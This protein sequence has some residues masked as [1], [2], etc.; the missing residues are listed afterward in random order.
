MKRNLFILICIIILIIT[1]FVAYK[2]YESNSIYH[3]S[4]FDKKYF[5]DMGFV[6]KS[7]N[8]KPKVDKNEILR[9][10]KAMQQQ[11]SSHP[12][13]IYMQYGLISTNTFTINAIS[14]DAINADP[15]LKEKDSISDIPVWIITFSGL[16][17]DNYKP[18][19]NVIGKQPLDTTNTII[20]AI[21]GKILLEFGSG[22]RP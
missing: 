15:I 19:K 18:D 11:S 9:I 5:S 21:S 22:K 16:L 13:G 8:I 6:I 12:K 20:D 17:P 10:T 3:F 14:E 1:G 2:T 4:S 7:T